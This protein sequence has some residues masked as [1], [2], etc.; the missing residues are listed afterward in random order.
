MARMISPTLE[1]SKQAVIYSHCHLQDTRDCTYGKEG[2]EIMASSHATVENSPEKFK[3][4]ENL[5]PVHHNDLG[6]IA[7]PL[8]ST[9]STFEVVTLLMYRPIKEGKTV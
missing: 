5:H 8:A 2:L 1:A 6:G 4:D 9:S 3:L 7:K